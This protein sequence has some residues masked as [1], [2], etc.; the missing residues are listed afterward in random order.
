M[1][2]LRLCWGIESYKNLRKIILRVFF[3]RILEPSWAYNVIWG[4]WWADVGSCRGYV[5]PFEAMLGHLESYKNPRNFLLFYE[6]FLGAFWSLL[7]PILGLRWAFV[8][9]FGA[10]LAAFGAK[11]STPT[12]AWFR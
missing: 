9:S 12:D 4:L 2:H 3:G 5:E 8:G 10:L 1:G 7:G 11:I 6:F